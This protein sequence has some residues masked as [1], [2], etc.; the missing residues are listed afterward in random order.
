MTAVIEEAQTTKTLKNEPGLRIF[1]NISCAP[2]E[3]SD[4]PAQSDQSLRRALWIV[5]VP[6][7]LQEGCKDF[8]Q[9]LRMH[10]LIRIFTTFRV[11]TGRTC[12]LLGN[13]LFAKYLQL[14]QR[15]QNLMHK[16]IH[17]YKKSHTVEKCCIQDTHN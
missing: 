2:S 16:Y 15:M 12:N 6:K 8:D 10:R 11:F 5:K 17:V 13:A 3:D 14:P 4:Q 1:Y 7:A 9:P